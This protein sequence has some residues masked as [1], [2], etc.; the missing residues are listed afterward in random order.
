MIQMMLLLNDKKVW[1]FYFEEVKGNH[2]V[3]GDSSMV[4]Q[5]LEQGHH[6]FKT[7]LQAGC[8]VVMEMQI[9]AALI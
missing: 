9:P 1:G 8:P 5:G 3:S 4:L 7:H 6:W 2:F